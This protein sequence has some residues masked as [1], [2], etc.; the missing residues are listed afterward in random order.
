[1]MRRLLTLAAGLAFGVSPLLR[2]QTQPQTP[3]P[4]TRVLKGRVLSEANRAPLV[5]AEIVLMDFARLTRTGLSGTFILDIPDGPFRLQIRRIGYLSR[6]FRF[7]TRSDTMEVEF[8]L[9]PSAVVLDSITVAG[10]ANTMSPRLAEFDRRRRISATGQF[11]GPA[12]LARHQDERLADMLRTLRGLRVVPVGNTLAA[13][14]M[15]GNSGM[16]SSNLNCY[17]AVWVD[18]ILVSSPGRPYDLELHRIDRTA[19]IEVYTGPSEL[20]IEF[21][22]PGSGG[23]GAI[24]IWTR[25]R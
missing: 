3:A 17:L 15:R 19:A 25:N 5:G 10:Q 24:V 9:T 16:N 11:L 6:A 18:G 4:A 20:P 2:G 13:V 21:E 1:M 12:D 8:T 7:R 23:C 14:S 22:G